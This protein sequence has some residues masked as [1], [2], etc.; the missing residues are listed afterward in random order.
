[1]SVKPCQTVWYMPIIHV[2]KWPAVT[3]IPQLV[4]YV[5]KKMEITIEFEPSFLKFIS[6]L[7]KN[8]KPHQKILMR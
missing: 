8:S 7:K 2:A 1:M 3:H 6:K 4:I 5:F